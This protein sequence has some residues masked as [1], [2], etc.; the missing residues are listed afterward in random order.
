MLDNIEEINAGDNFE[1]L[2][3]PIIIP[4]IILY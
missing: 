4:A 2:I 3:N 1:D